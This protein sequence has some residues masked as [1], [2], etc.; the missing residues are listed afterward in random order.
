[1]LHIFFLRKV[2][3]KAPFNSSNTLF[4]VNNVIRVRVRELVRPRAHAVEVQ[5]GDRMGL[6]GG[7][8][9]G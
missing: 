7:W 5:V 9:L 6:R 1:M 2:S 8:Y 4:N 3:V